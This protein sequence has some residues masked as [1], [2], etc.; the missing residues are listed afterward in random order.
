MS[1]FTPRFAALAVLLLMIAQMAGGQ[2]TQSPQN[3]SSKTGSK[4]SVERFP[5]WTVGALLNE[6][7]TLNKDINDLNNDISWVGD[8][9]VK[10]ADKAQ[11]EA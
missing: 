1:N 3:I 9:I 8:A 4:E 6:R 2:G 5:G 7:D 10:R 11:L